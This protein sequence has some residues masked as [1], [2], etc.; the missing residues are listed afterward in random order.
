MNRC[1][2]FFVCVSKDVDRVF[3]LA[4]RI[5][6]IEI[7]GIL[8][9]ITIIAKQVNGFMYLQFEHI[10]MGN[11]VSLPYK[12]KEN[13]KNE[14]NLPCFVIIGLEVFVLIHVVLQWDCELCRC[15]L[16]TAH[17]THVHTYLSHSIDNNGTARNDSVK[18]L[19]IL[20]HIYILRN[21]STHPHI[22]TQTHTIKNDDI[23]INEKKK[24][25]TISSGVILSNNL[26]LS[27]QY[28]FYPSFLFPACSW[29]RIRKYPIIFLL[30]FVEHVIYSWDNI[31]SL[32]AAFLSQCYSYAAA[33]V[34]VAVHFLIL[35]GSNHNTF[36]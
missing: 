33:V 29:I 26:F 18:R 30:R 7:G 11:D 22:H 36:E 23:M 14:K 25:T 28:H 3:K 13:R 31:F 20:C 16:C 6:L 5:Y 19:C 12:E 2:F 21:A 32:S 4:M 1:G 9:I 17:S 15:T 35:F 10:S 8:K 24:H 34:A 27:S